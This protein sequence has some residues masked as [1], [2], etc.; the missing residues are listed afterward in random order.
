MKRGTKILIVILGIIF[1][2]FLVSIIFSIY[3]QSCTLIGCASTLTLI[4]PDSIQSDNLVV[5]V[6]DYEVIDI[7]N[8]KYQNIG[9]GRYENRVY[10]SSQHPVSGELITYMNSLKIGYRET[11]GSGTTIVYSYSDLSIDYTI[12]QP[13]GPRCE[14]TCYNAAINL[15]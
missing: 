14:P 8:G 2:I 9:S 7:C 4:L 5:M 3:G 6:D 10:L 15:E 12:S 11:C 13:N 1:F